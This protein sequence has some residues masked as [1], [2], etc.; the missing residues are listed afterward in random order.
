MAESKLGTGE[1]LESLWS[2]GGLT[3]KEAE[4]RVWHDMQGKRICSIERY[5]LAYNFLLAVF[6]T[7]VAIKV[8]QW[9][10]A[11][12]FVV[13]AFA[14]IYYFAPNAK[15]QHW[16]WIYP[17]FAGRSNHVG[18]GFGGIAT[19]SAFFELIEQDLWIAW[20]GHHPVAVVLCHRSS[21][22][23]RGGQ[24]NATIEH[25]AAEH[26]HRKQKLPDK[27]SLEWA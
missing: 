24:I 26:G 10:C 17:G 15:E 27:S 22:F 25:A 3:W 4:K 21:L 20:R 7:Y 8:V 18:I 2:L 6:G 14:T 12:A 19:L 5:E 23:D 9:I 1:Q 16:Y 11:S 13:L